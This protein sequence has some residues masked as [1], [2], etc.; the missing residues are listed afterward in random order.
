MKCSQLLGALILLL[1]ILLSCNQGSG[2]RILKNELTVRQ[3]TG[4][5]SQIQSMAAVTGAAINPGET[6]VTDCIITV[7]FYD[8]EKT[9]LGVATVKKESLGPGETWNF[10][11]QLTGP[12]AWKARSYDIIPSNK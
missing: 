2:F 1:G 7:I 5:S 10:S 9:K 11:A 6:A 4:N 3:F 8:S 12:D